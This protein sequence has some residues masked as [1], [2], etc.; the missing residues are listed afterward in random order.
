MIAIVADSSVHLT[1]EEARVMGVSVVPMHYDAEG[2]ASRTEG[3]IGENGD[4]ESLVERYA[5]RMHTSQATYADFMETFERLLARGC[6]IL[7]LTI[8]S[9]LSGNYGNAVTAARE[10]GINRV[11]VVD[12]L[13]ASGGM[14][15]LA[16][17]A[18]RMIDAGLGIA[19]VEEVLTRLREGIHI[20]FT[21]DDITPLRMSGRLSGVRLSVSTLLNIRPVFKLI[22]GA[23]VATGIARGL[24]DQFRALERNLPKFPCECV[25]EGFMAKEQTQTLLRRVEAAGHRAIWR[26]IGPVLGAHLGVGSMGL[27]WMEGEVPLA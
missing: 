27:C 13:S 3:Y 9:R 23:I 14:Y 12:S 1:R 26:H 15:L 16:R 20:T 6:E 2:M 24:S 25:V 11:R 17:A 5:G 22:G 7:C 10:L 18:R 19:R 21:V 8:S 4:C